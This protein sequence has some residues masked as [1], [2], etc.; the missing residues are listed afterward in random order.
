MKEFNYRAIN[1][2]GRMISGTQSAENE[3]DLAARLGR[4]QLELVSAKRAGVSGGLFARKSLLPKELIA[5]LIHIQTLSEAGVPLLEALV[6]LRDSAD[7]VSAKRFVSDVVDRIEGGA[8]LSEAF[9]QSPAGIDPVVVSLIKT[10]EATGKLPEVLSELVE[11]LKWS[12]EIATQT[13]KLLSAP[14]F[15]ATVVLG[16]VGFLMVFLVPQLLSFIKGMGGELPF[17]TVAL[18]AF[19]GFLTQYGIYLPIV[20]AAAFASLVFMMRYSPAVRLR[21]DGWKLTIP[22]VGPILKK[23]TLARFANSFALMYRSGVSVLDALNYCVALSTNT[24]FQHAIREA[25]QSISGGEKISNAFAATGLFPP[26]VIR[27]LRVG[28]TTGGLD[29]AMGN[30]SYFYTREVNDSIEK[31]QATI[32]PALTIF[33]GGMVA[34][35][36]SAVLLPIYD[37]V[38]KVKI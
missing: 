33:L 23:I 18:V 16:A 5:I 30:V 7:A 4:L 24:A 14:A 10:G 25:Q 36:M 27:M 29:K 37:L 17:Q 22:P 6:D 32:Q 28:E 11:S 8:T 38:S 2:D 1:A 15:A 31:L 9:G 21:V 35:I 12:D 3:D 26:L 19:S 13:K 20:G 34:W